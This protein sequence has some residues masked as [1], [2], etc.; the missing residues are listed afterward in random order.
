VEKIVIHPRGKYQA[1]QI[2]IFGQLAAIL[3]LSE[4][5]WVSE[6]SQR[7]LV[8]GARFELATFRL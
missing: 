5:T 2:E 6:E 8:A 1:P 3:R 4:A 7:A